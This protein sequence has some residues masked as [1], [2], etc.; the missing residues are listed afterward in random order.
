MDDLIKNAPSYQ[1]D[2]DILDARG[3]NMT[4]EEV[5][6]LPTGK[7][8]QRVQSLN[9]SQNDLVF[10][11]CLRRRI[12]N[13]NSRRRSVEHLRRLAREL[14][15]VRAC[16]RDALCER[17]ALLA[18]DAELRGRCQMLRDHIVQV[19]KDRADPTPVPDVNVERIESQTNK[20]CEPPVT[21]TVSKQK[22]N[23]FECRIEKLVQQSVNHI[24]KEKEKKIVSAK[25]VF[26]DTKTIDVP[27]DID[28]KIEYGS[29]LECPLDSKTQTLNEKINGKPDIKVEYD[30]DS[31]DYHKLDYDK[32]KVQ[33]DCPVSLGGFEQNGVLNLCVKER[34]R[35]H[36]RKQLA[37][38]RITYVFMDN[39][40]G[41]IDFSI[42]KE[43]E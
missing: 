7:Y 20:K 13:R 41:V 39:D 37:P 9:L 38:K 5:A 36:G 11:K 12:K 18:T 17:R 43:P 40:D 31:S 2:Q 33:S 14:R 4:V 42:K 27:K 24:Y 32:T 26:L 10:L 19:L 15:A 34:R 30:T 8:S 6:G 22:E 16:R 23:L 29:S 25:T 1:L 35:S 3:I 21:E 28:I